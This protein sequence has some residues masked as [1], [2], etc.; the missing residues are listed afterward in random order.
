M[1]VTW[2]AVSLLTGASITTLIR[3]ALANEHRRHRDE[4]TSNV[5]ASSSDEP[6][7]MPTSASFQAFLRLIER[8]N[9]SLYRKLRNFD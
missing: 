8:D 9:P 7:L 5:Q 1:L 6:G 2:L 4:A 3:A